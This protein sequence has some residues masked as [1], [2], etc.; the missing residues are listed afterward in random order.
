MI[1]DTAK[2]RN[3]S[4]VERNDVFDDF[5]F[6]INPENPIWLWYWLYGDNQVLYLEP[7][8]DN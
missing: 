6:G 2:V 4:R 5:A 8:T 7:V 3:S 1:R